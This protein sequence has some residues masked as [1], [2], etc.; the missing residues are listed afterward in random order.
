MGGSETEWQCWAESGRATVQNLTVPDAEF[1][2]FFR[3]SSLCIKMSNNEKNINSSTFI[4][5]KIICFDS[6]EGQIQKFIP[7][8]L[9]NQNWIIFKREECCRESGFLI[10]FRVVVPGGTGLQSR[11]VYCT[12]DRTAS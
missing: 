6:F 10:V 2:P 11:F 3:N 8:L 4:K 1:L 12:T 9:W 5:I 7:R